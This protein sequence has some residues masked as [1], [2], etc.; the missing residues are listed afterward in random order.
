MSVVEAREVDAPDGIE[1]L[2]WVLLTSEPVNRFEQAWTIIDWYEK[3]Q[4]IEEYH[5]C[6]KTG[7]RVEHRQYKTSTRLQRVTG[8]LSV[9]AVRL[10]K[11]KSVART[12]PDRP[13]EQ[14]VPRAW[15]T[16]LQRMHGNGSITTVGEFYRALA[17]LGGFLGRKSDGEPGWITL[18][19]GL[20]KLTL[21]LRGH[22]AMRQRCG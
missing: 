17:R 21:C 13:V 7:C 1:P 9:I 18:W 11:L 5:K 8:L 2:H 15:R 14:L 6:L 16:M 4:I 20:E 22:R 12:D 3:Q 19:R 10:L